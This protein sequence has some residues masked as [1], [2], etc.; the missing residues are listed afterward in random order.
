L[1][2][3]LRHFALVSG[4]SRNRDGTTRRLPGLVGAP[5]SM[6]DF[7]SRYG[8]SE[9]CEPSRPPDPAPPSA[10]T[11]FAEAGHRHHVERTV[12][13]GQGEQRSRTA[14][15]SAVREAPGW[16]ATGYSEPR[17]PPRPATTRRPPPTPQAEA[18]L[19]RA[20][21]VG[22]STPQRQPK[23]QAGPQPRSALSAT[24]DRARRPLDGISAARGHG[25]MTSSLQT[26][27][28]K[29][30]RGHLSTSAHRNRPSEVSFG[31][32]GCCTCCC[33][34]AECT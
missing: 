5:R 19:L 17:A 22:S 16:L 18:G 15:D 21:Y 30:N 12:L 29:V 14:I 6:A 1:L 11:G 31:Q 7:A 20:Q 13:A 2:V 9:S 24:S 28:R 3:V 4:I 23:P 26:S 10:R 34:R 25:R 8:L 33:I 27:G 32:C